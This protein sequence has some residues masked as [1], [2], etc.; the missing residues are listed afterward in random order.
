MISRAFKVSSIA[1]AALLAACGGGGDSVSPTPTPT[2]PVSVTPSTEAALDAV[3]GFL[4]KR[5]AQVATA[6]G[7]NGAAVF[8]LSDGCSLADGRSKAYN[9]DEFN[10]EPLAVARG[11]AEVGSTRIAP[12]V[13]A[14]RTETNPD[15]TTRREI[16]IKFVINYKDGSKN[17]VA[18]NTIISGSSSGAKMADGSTCATPDSKTDWRFYGNRKVVETA[19]VATNERIERTALAT[20]L[21]VSPA[22]VYSKYI[23][24]F[25]SDPA[26]V[27]TYAIVTGPGLGFGTAAGKSGSLKLLSVRLLRNA[28]ELTGKRNNFVDWLDTDGFRLCSNAAGND[29]APADTVNC[30]ADGGTGTSWGSY[31]RPSGIDLDTRFASLNINA[32]AVYTIDVYGDDGWKTVNGQLGKTP[33]ASYKS[34][35]D[36]APLSAAALAGTGPAADLFA[37]VTSSTKTA[38]EIATA[39]RAKAAISTGQTWTAPGAMPDGRAVALRRNWSF[40][41]GQASPAPSNATWPASRKLDFG[42]PGALATSA[43]VNIPA[44]VAALVNPTYAETALQYFNRNGNFITSIYSYQ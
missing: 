25:V 33:I 21:P 39:V 11:Q 19:V 4:A 18:E 43:T 31:N 38:A 27:A 26:K 7:A 35:L 6:I 10:A 17:E 3:K 22:V 34:T 15:L 14:D 12:V 29:T 40:E 9:V 32:G 37:R 16:D 30:A 24:L 23:T 44:P 41:S 20:G 42:Y 8:S 2:P 1:A 13:V 36:N 28:P 5:D